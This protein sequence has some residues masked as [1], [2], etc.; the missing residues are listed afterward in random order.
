MRANVSQ[1]HLKDIQ[2]HSH[3]SGA[4]YCVLYILTKIYRRDPMGQ[5]VRIN[6][7]FLHLADYRIG[8]L[9]WLCIYFYVFSVYASLKNCLKA[10]ARLK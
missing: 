1:K 3:I 4:G 2:Y 7:H 8:F 5:A 9:L 10:L 6:A